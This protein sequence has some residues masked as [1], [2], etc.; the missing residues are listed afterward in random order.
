MSV[1]LEETTDWPALYAI[2]AA[3]FG[4]LAEADLVRRMQEDADLILSVTAY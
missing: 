3:A 1:R 4:Q 2:Y